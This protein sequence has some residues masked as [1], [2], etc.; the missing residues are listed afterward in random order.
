MPMPMVVKAPNL[1]LRKVG[2]GVSKR[3]FHYS[4][5][6]YKYRSL[7]DISIDLLNFEQ[8]LSRSYI[9]QSHQF[10]FYSTT[11]RTYKEPGSKHKITLIS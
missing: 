2:L 3:L 7:Y 1:V 10:V 6:L 11:E 5:G 8:F 9:G 4:T